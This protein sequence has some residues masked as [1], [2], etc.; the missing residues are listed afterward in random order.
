MTIRLIWQSP[1]VFWHS[2]LYLKINSKRY[3]LIRV[4]PR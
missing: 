4:G 1:K 3:R 2:G